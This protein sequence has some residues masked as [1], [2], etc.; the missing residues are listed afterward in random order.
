MGL[1]EFCDR[2]DFL[3]PA[4][5][6]ISRV[7]RLEQA[8]VECP[9]RIDVEVFFLPEGNNPNVEDTEL[10]P[11]SGKADVVESVDDQSDANLQNCGFETVEVSWDQGGIMLFSPWEVEV[12]SS[13]PS[14]WPTRPNLSDEEKA[15]VRRALDEIR[16]VKVVNDWFVHP[17]DDTRYPD[18]SACVRTFYS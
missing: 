18:S 2:T 12:S 11:Y 14:R 1:F 3:I 6:Y 4:G 5:L 15:T 10:I 13:G 8:A 17:V 9:R 7:S 16:K